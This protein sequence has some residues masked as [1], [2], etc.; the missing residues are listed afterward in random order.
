MEE[1]KPCPVCG[2]R[3]AEI[4]RYELPVK[5]IHDDVASAKSAELRR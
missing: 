3:K 2:N 1:L 5:D 4:A